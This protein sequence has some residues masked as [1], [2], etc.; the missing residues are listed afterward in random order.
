MTLYRNIFL[1]NRLSKINYNI[2][3][4]ACRC[5][6]YRSNVT[7]PPLFYFKQH[8]ETS[9]TIN[10]KK[11]KYNTNFINKKVA[12]YTQTKINQGVLHTPQ[13]HKHTYIRHLYNKTIQIDKHLLLL[14]KKKYHQYDQ[15]YSIPP[16]SRI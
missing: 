16:V 14:K 12:R 9:L 10:K 4:I 3:Y 2:T 1:Y 13:I 6:K 15:T 7:V 8:T 11:F 5:N